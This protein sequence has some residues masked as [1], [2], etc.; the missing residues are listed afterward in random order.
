MLVL[1]TG[2]NGGQEQNSIA[3]ILRGS[4]ENVVSDQRQH[5]PRSVMSVICVAIVSLADEK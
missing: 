3:A 4:C 5:P 1:V 2:L